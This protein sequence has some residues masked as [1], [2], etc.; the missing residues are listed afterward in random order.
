MVVS[1]V[2]NLLYIYLHNVFIIKI[3]IVGIQ[4]PQP[5]ICFRKGTEGML[6]LQTK[7]IKQ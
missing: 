4:R 3:E 5:I 2:E 7:N 1:L 6:N